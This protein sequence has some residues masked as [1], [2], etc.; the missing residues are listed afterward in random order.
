MSGSK[1]SQV[2]ATSDPSLDGPESSENGPVSSDV[3]PSDVS[4]L[5]QLPQLD[6]SIPHALL[7]SLIFHIV[8]MLLLSMIVFG[9][10]RRQLAPTE[11]LVSQV[12]NYSVMESPT[13]ELQPDLAP[14]SEP[15][16]EPATDLVVAV[17]LAAPPKLELASQDT[18]T[19]QPVSTSSESRQSTSVAVPRSVAA[20]Q[21]RVSNAGGR[22]GEVQF[23]LA[24]QN[25]N[26]VDLHVIVP[27]GERISH[28]VRTS[29]CNGKLDVDM[30]VNGES[31]DPVENVRWIQNAPWGR[32][33]VIVNLFSLHRSLSGGFRR[34]R[35]SQFQLL[36]QLGEDSILKSDV[37]RMGDQIAV[38]RFQYIPS[39][40]SGAERQQLL[41]QLANLQSQ[42]EQAAEPLLERARKFPADRMRDRM[43]NSIV[44]RYPHTEAAIEAMQLLGGQIRKR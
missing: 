41:D 44:I 5:Q 39:S 11:L 27:S 40:V 30:N 13:F 33:T 24:W 26:D 21:T 28:M 25:T 1:S 9:V 14:E 12:E 4:W 16:F 22:K 7:V 10:G 43:L 34:Y 3:P 36:A 6:L 29:R 37:V 32:Y 35:G 8:L 31:E 20:I 42:E 17:D 18:L 38:Y 2:P 15:V 23:A 19:A